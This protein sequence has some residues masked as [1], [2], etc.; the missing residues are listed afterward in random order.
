MSRKREFAGQ[1]A[2]LPVSTR[3]AAQ[4]LHHVLSTTLNSALCDQHMLFTPARAGQQTSKRLLSWSEKYKA[5]LAA[6][7]RGD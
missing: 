7:E 5:L 1:C 6:P 2:T 4:T 3:F